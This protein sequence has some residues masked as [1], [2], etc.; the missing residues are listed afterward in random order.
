MSLQKGQRIEHISA[1][2]AL[3][4][5]G[6]HDW[7]AIHVS[8]DMTSAVGEHAVGRFLGLELVRKAAKTP[9]TLIRDRQEVSK[10]TVSMEFIFSCS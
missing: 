3:K 10:D 7:G 6:F 8:V 1:S 2:W 4:E 9:S 5:L